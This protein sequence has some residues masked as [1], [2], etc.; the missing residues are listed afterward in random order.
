[1][2]P[3]AEIRRDRR[4][5]VRKIVSCQ[6][7]GKKFLAL[8]V[9]L[10]LGG[11]KIEAP[12]HLETNQ[13]L[14]S[15]LVLDRKPLPSEGRVVYSFSDPQGQVLAGIEFVEIAEEDRKALKTFLMKQKRL[16]QKNQPLFGEKEYPLPEA[17]KDTDKPKEQLI[18]ELSAL[19]NRLATLE[20]E[21]KESSRAFQALDE[22]EE[23]FQELSEL[24]PVG[25]AEFDLDMKLKYANRFL[26]EMSGYTEE[27]FK[28]QPDIS[29]VLAP[30]ELER[31]REAIKRIVSGE[32]VGSGEYRL[33]R[34][35]GA[36]FYG[37]VNSV[38][39]VRDG[40]VVGVRSV[41]QD[42]TD[43]KRTEESLKVQ[44]EILQ[45]IIDEI[46]VLLCFYDAS[47][48]V[49]RV[50]RA[51]ERLIG[52]SLEEL[53]KTDVIKECY[54]D[55]DYRKQVWDHMM[56]ATSEWRDFRIRCRNGTYLESSWANVRLSD[57]SQIGIGVD[58]TKRR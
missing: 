14:S 38:A 56:K 47:G 5:P 12:H 22:T 39:I 11:M 17:K 45:T 10:S 24:L 52:W 31:A 58:I 3:G 23:R 25:V 7:G 43:W 26:Y 57:G 44:T 21:R 54:P 15:V 30:E 6:N 19:R 16:P 35:D 40:S 32:S 20:W 51:F 13:R 36:Q 1:M 4:Y 34:K 18:E 50:N 41:V 46:P 29:P 48:A 9:N 37:E 2:S 27:D 49:K 55:P 8:T 53:G 42:I 33:V 28:R